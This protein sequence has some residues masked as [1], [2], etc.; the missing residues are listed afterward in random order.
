[1]WPSQSKMDDDVFPN[2]SQQE[3]APPAPLP[4]PVKVKKP[5]SRTPRR[6]KPRVANPEFQMV[7]WRD[8]DEIADTILDAGRALRT[9]QR[10]YAGDGRYTSVEYVERLRRSE[11]NCDVS[12]VA[13]HAIVVAICVLCVWVS[14]KF[15]GSVVTAVVG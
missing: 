12:T 1:M 2:P 8:V 13:L 5:R 6:T 11:T 3:A 10:W 4:A 15:A 14:V 9:M 7:F